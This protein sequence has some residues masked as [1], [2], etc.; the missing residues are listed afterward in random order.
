MAAELACLFLKGLKHEE[1]ERQTQRHQPP[2][3]F[4]LGKIKESGEGDKRLC[5]VILVEFVLNSTMKVVPH[6]VTN[7]KHFLL[8]QIQHEYILSQLYTAAQAWEQLKGSLE[9]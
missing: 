4:V 9:G 6:T 8:Y 3:R 2:F 1:A 5:R 7:V